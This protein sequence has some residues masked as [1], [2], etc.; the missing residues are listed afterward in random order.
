MSSLIEPYAFARPS[1]GCFSVD[2]VPAGSYDFLV[3]RPLLSIFHHSYRFIRRHYD[4][5]AI[6]WD[7]VVEELQAAKGKGALI[8]CCSDWGR[9]WNDLVSTSDASL[10]RYGVCT[11][12]APR[13]SVAAVGRLSERERFKRKAGHSARESALEQLH[14]TSPCPSDVNMSDLSDLGWEASREFAEVPV[15]GSLTRTAGL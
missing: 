10:L 6:L 14:L 2:K 8:C 7:T 5:K 11:R 3:N 15:G 9:Q 4:Q 12:K 13:S 1:Q